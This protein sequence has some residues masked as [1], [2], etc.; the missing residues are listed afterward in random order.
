MARAYRIGEA[1]ALAGVTVRTLHHYD[2][3]DVLRPSGRSDAGYRF[4][5][6][7]DVLRLQQIVTLRGLGFGLD[8]IGAML[9]RPDVDLDASMRAQRLALRRRIV[10]LDRIDAAIADLLADHAATG[11]WDW[12]TIER[13]TAASRVAWQDGVREM[14]RYYT[15]EQIAEFA[16]WGEDAGPAE[17]AEVERLWAELLTEIRA[18]RAAGIDA[19]SPEARRLA[20]RADA[21]VER[22]FRGH[23]TMKTAVRNAYEAG[24]FADNPAFPSA[25]DF[26]FLDRAR[27]GERG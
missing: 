2:R 12:A 26:A 21:L 16:A 7:A 1:A 8:R 18:A 11:G 15:P 23:E 17:I 3:I 10:D 20:E 22:Q 6:E 27:R 4:Y 25:D 24:A 5:D 13:A 9:D 14:E 19:A